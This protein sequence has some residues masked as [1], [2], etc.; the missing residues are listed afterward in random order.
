MAKASK[1]TTKPSISD[2]E[3]AAGKGS[4]AKPATRGTSRGGKAPKLGNIG[5]GMPMDFT[6]MERL[7]KDAER[8]DH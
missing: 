4:A 5:L 2:T 8:L 7:K 3:Q 6:E 1:K